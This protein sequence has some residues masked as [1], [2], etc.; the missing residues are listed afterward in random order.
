M[1]GSGVW[2]WQQFL[3]VRVMTWKP[4]DGGNQI[5]LQEHQRHQAMTW[6][7]C[8]G[9]GEEA[10]AARG[11]VS[12]CPDGKRK[13]EGAR[14]NTAGAQRTKTV[15]PF[16]Y[17]LSALQDSTGAQGRSRRERP[18]PEGLKRGA[19]GGAKRQGETIPFGGRKVWFWR[20]KGNVK[21]LQKAPYLSKFAFFVAQKN[22]PYLS[23]FAVTRL[24]STLPRS[25]VFA[26]VFSSLAAVFHLF[27]AETPFFV[28]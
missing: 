4:C 3:A 7:P 9:V 19:A 17:P 11:C 22:V 14:K 2:P 6:K 27:V 18:R 25:H 12:R 24:R 16:A 20:A 10:R 23:H 21:F 13:A 15:H 26:A 28:K 8:D 5:L 1:H